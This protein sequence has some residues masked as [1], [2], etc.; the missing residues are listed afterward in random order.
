MLLFFKI[1]TTGLPASK[2]TPFLQQPRAVKM[3]WVV[4]NSRG[5]LDSSKTY[6]IRPDGFTI[7]SSSVAI[8]GITTQTARD[9]GVHLSTALSEFMIDMNRSQLIIS[10]NL[11]FAE[12]V[13][14]GEFIRADINPSAFLN[15][16]RLCTMKSSRNYCRMLPSKHN[17]RYKYPSLPELYFNLYGK[18]YK[19]HHDPDKDVIIC[20][21]CFF[22]LKKYGI[23]SVPDDFEVDAC[24][25]MIHHSEFNSSGIAS[26]MAGFHR[27]RGVR[28]HHTDSCEKCGSGVRLF[29]RDLMQLL[30]DLF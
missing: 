20:I 18:V 8:H 21:K 29:L 6:L 26:P 13:I 25:G 19:R 4:C 16:N 30:R 10:H 17:F 11:E 3:A 28:S 9:F 7:P 5:Y 15:T 23:I 22:Q 12:K 1:A 2:R 27:R 24:D 14:C